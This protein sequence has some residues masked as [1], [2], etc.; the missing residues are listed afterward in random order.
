[1]R[2]RRRPAVG[3]GWRGAPPP[4]SGS[5]TGGRGT[6]VSRNL[7]GASARVIG[8]GALFLLGV[9][10]C[11]VLRGSFWLPPGK[12]LPK[13]KDDTPERPGEETRGEM[14]R[15]SSD[16]VISRCTRSSP[17]QSGTPSWMP[18]PQEPINAP[19]FKPLSLNWV[20]SL[21]LKESQP[22]HRPIMHIPA[23]KVLFLDRRK[24]QYVNF[25]SHFIL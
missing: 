25:S 6:Q 24:S 8:T 20:S 1:M 19:L 15:H 16:C 5:E 17:V 13:D 9:P 10:G 21:Q 18:Q 12:L 4:S 23:N 11:E 7:P 3:P 14:G 2:C 22:I